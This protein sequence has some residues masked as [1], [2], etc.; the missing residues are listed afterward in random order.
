M[1][2]SA[3][4]FKLLDPRGFLVSGSPMLSDIEARRASL[5]AET[6]LKLQIE[7]RCLSDDLGYLTQAKFRMASIR[8][9]RRR[10]APLKATL[11][12]W[13]TAPVQI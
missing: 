7:R 10:I 13:K 12:H 6:E 9:A 2:N 8:M 5:I 1:L 4:Y 11:Q 3:S